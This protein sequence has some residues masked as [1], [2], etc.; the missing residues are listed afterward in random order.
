MEYKNKILN[1]DCL[2]FMNNLPNNVF[3]VII[4]DPPIESSGEYNSDKTN[5]YEDWAYL[6]ISECSRILKNNGKFIFISNF[7]HR[8]LYFVLISKYFGNYKLI[9]CYFPYLLEIIIHDKNFKDK[10]FKTKNNN[11]ET[12]E[13]KNNNNIEHHELKYIN[14]IKNQTFDVCSTKL[15]NFLIK[16]IFDYYINQNDFV[17]DVFSGSCV[18]PKISKENDIDFVATEINADYCNQFYKSTTPH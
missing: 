17:Y 18:V 8:D 2:D 1:K 6:W 5:T 9:K 3:D 15:P 11:I 10:N 4:A 16:I 14:S 12:W 13:F 7:A